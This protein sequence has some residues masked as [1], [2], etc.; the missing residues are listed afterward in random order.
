[1]MTNCVLIVDDEKPIRVTL[2]RALENIKFQTDSAMNGADALEKL[3]QREYLLMLLDLKMPG[4]NGIA[5]LSEARQIHPQMPVIMMTAQGTLSDT[6][7]AMKLGVVDFIQKPFAPNEVCD[8]VRSVL[9]RQRVES[10]HAVAYETLLTLIKECLKNRQFDE[11]ELYL[12]RAIAR[13][14]HRPE[15]MTLLGIM[16]EMQDHQRDAVKLYQAALSL[17]PTYQFAQQNLSRAAA[18]KASTRIILEE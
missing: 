12:R 2:A 4:M 7:E 10:E 6:V 8:L 17:N 18:W 15:A 3:K 9:E 13:A 5:V 16:L 11:A 14:P 1:M